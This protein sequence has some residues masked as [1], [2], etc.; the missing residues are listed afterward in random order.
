MGWIGH[1]S[2]PGTQ[3]PACH[4]PINQ[5]IVAMPSQEPVCSLLAQGA[6]MNKLLG[7]EFNWLLVPAYLFVL[8]T[9]LCSAVACLEFTCFN[10]LVTSIGVHGGHE[11][12]MACVTGEWT[13]TVY[14][15]KVVR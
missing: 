8:L 1:R 3:D 11:A 9:I 10:E 13:H 15:C 4:L 2:A 6:T 12:V 5:G 7:S 14:F